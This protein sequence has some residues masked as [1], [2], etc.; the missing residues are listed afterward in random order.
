MP[1]V[2]QQAQTSAARSRVLTLGV[3]E[4]GEVR[5]GLLRGDGPQLTERS[6]AAAA[7]RTA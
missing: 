5:Y 4:S 1:A 3:L 7:T 2:G 6:A